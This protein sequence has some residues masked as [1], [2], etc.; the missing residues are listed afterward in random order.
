MRRWIIQGLLFVIGFTAVERFCHKQT[1]GFRLQ[2][3][4]ADLPYNSDWETL[5]PGDHEIRII[6]SILSQP[7]YFLASGGES[8]AFVSD[9]GKYVLKFFKLH[10]MRPKNLSDAFLPTYFREKVQK[11]RIKKLSTLFSSCLLA[12]ER[13]R[14]KTGLVYLHLN[15]TDNLHL[16][17]KLFDAIGAKHSLNFDQ[18]PF[19]LQERASMAYPTLSALTEARELEAAKKRLGSLVDLIVARCAVGLSDHDARKRNFGFVGEKAVEIDIGSFTIDEML[20][21][22]LETKKVLMHETL[23]LRRYIKKRHPELIDFL[24][25]KLN[26]Y[27]SEKT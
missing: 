11:Q 12:Y 13:F 17:C 25:K 23:K 4:Q 21:T 1:H 2:K 6:Q 15:N 16:D 8:Y 18:I 10:H 3:I 5:L 9:D 14:E 20:K 26:S 22:P 7:Y 27:L 19:A 24:D